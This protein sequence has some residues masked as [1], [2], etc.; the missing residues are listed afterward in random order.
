MSVTVSAEGV[1][2]LELY[3]ERFPTAAKRAMSVAI[4]ETARDVALP[5][6]RREIT[7]Q[8]N[9]PFGYLDDGDRLSIS[10]FAYPERLEAKLTARDRPTSLNRF[11]TGDLPAEA[12]Y[13]AGVT[14][15]VK[16]GSV[17]KL[18][19]A[20]AVPL[21]NGNIGLAIRLRPGETLTG[22]HDFTPIQLFP[23]VFLLYGPSVNQVFQTVAEDIELPVTNALETEFL[24]QLNLRI[25]GQVDD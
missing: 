25:S 18:P 19:G 11:V 2:D 9:F 23:N 22:V 15:A 8:V 14:V 16:P 10:Q 17:R 4:N 13:R 5:E 1:A 24:R 20:F 6:A 21:K 7:A 3:F 12:T